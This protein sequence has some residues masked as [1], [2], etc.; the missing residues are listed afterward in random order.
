MA[1]VYRNWILYNV[2]KAIKNWTEYPFDW[3]MLSEYNQLQAYYDS[4]KQQIRTS[5]INKWVAVPNDALLSTYPSYIDQIVTWEIE[6]IFVPA[7]F[8]T[9]SQYASSY[10]FVVDNLCD[11][12]RA[13][14]SEYFRYFW[15]RDDSSS[16][17]HY[18]IWVRNKTVWNDPWFV[19]S[20]ERFDNDTFEY[21]WRM[22]KDNNDV[23]MSFLFYVATWPQARSWYC[24]NVTNTT[25]S[26]AVSLWNTTGDTP[27]EAVL[28][29][30]TTS[31][32][33]TAEESISA[34]NI[35][36]AHFDH[37]VSGR[38]TLVVDL[39]V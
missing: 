2:G 31:W 12:T 26:T 22:K 10:A 36:T 38:W 21:G 1:D 20:S 18:R 34:L 29:A 9:P 19:Y 28:S 24:I 13:D 33:I 35:T 14:D 11:T 30:W 5:I 3:T 7:S 39:N 4:A 37:I 16:E 27:S 15:Y 32:W 17:N 25:I 23:K 6:G 8:T